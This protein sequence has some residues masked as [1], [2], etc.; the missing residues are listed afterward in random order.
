MS[1]ELPQIPRFPQIQKEEP[2]TTENIMNKA[3]EGIEAVKET[4]TDVIEQAKTTVESIRDSVSDTMG[5]FSSNVAVDAEASQDFLTSNTIISRIGFVLLVLILFLFALRF[6]MSILGY[7]LAPTTSPYI[8]YGMMNGNQSQII[9]Q[10]PENSKSVSILRSNNQASGIECTWSVWLFINPGNSPSLDTS[11]QNVF[12]KGDGNFDPNTGL[13]S[14]DNGPGMYLYE[15]SDLSGNLS[16]VYNLISFFNIIGGKDVSYNQFSVPETYIDV[17]G[18]PLQKWFHVALRL[19]NTVLDVYI[20]GTLSKRTVLPDVPKQNYADIYV[21]GNGGFSG[22]LSNLRYYPYALNVF[23][24]NSVSWW[25][26]NLTAASLVSS[27]TEVNNGY[28]YLSNL[29]Y[30]LHL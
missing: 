3:N 2:T 22:S 13:S 29:W 8:I 15:T 5:D 6:S 21:C 30:N 10:N 27:A 26:P 1:D 14:V 28:T 19:Q 25:G 9:S 11:F 24:I 17:S 20:N 23:E 16:G 18:V 12:V 7:F 4:A